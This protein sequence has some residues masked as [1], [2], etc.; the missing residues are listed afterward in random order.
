MTAADFAA[1]LDARP[2]GSRKWMAKCPAHRD[3]LPSL[4]VGEGRDGRVLLNCFSGC[5]LSNILRAMK[6]QRRDLFSTE[7][8]TSEQRQRLEMQRDRER[9]AG[10]LVGEAAADVRMLETHVDRLGAELARMDDQDPRGPEATARFH[11]V[12]DEMHIAEQKWQQ[13]RNGPRLAPPTR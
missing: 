2:N 11:A 5:I 10:R 1:L 9:R 7:P 8:P 6:L 13:M 3:R 12:C 4:S